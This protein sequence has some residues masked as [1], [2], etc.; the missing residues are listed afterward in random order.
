MKYG[1][2][3]RIPTQDRFGCGYVF[4]SS[5]I[6]EEEA[7]KEIEEYLGFEPEYPRKNKGGFKFKAGCYEEP[8]I[9]NCISVGLSGGFIEPLEATSLWVAISYLQFALSNP[10]ILV[11]RD[12]FHAD[13]FNERCQ[14]LNNNVVDFI[15]FHYMSDREDTEFWKKFKDIKKA[16]DYVQYLVK[17]W[18]KRLPQIDDHTMKTNWAMDS[19]TAVGTGIGK[20][21]STL[22]N[23][24]ININM[25]FTF[26][27]AVYEEYKSKQ[28]II[29]GSCTDH[30]T[31]LKELHK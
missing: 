18:E 13:Q 9:K 5:L 29:A 7:V 11:Y 16:P 3:W 4:D 26:S 17:S 12:Q 8:W 2:M 1:W 30:G 15:Y 23:E 21:N 27:E 6:S 24:A 22:A 20:A 31:F 19:W 10:E 25:S 28:N 14:T